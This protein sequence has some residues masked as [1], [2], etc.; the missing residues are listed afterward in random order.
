MAPTQ[1]SELP[2]VNAQTLAEAAE[3]LDGAEN[4]VIL[5][6]GGSLS[7]THELRVLAERLNAP[8]I[9]TTNGKGALD[10][11]HR[12]SLGA[13]LRLPVV[14]NIAKSADVLLVIGAKLGEA[15]LWVDALEAESIH[16]KISLAK[17]RAYYK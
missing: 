12:L 5:A 7:A 15:D 1:P 11:Y 17:F 3:L 6:G 8:V 13:N 9:T 16:P 2:S 10:E 14:R 4:P